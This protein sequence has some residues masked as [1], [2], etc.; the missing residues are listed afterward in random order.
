[1][2]NAFIRNYAYEQLIGTNLKVS[3]LTGVKFRKYGKFDQISRNVVPT[4]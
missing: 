3:I 4:K 1:M 2:G